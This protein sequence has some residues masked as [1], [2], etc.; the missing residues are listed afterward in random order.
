M[1]EPERSGL[2]S[3]SGWATGGPSTRRP[4]EY[5]GVGVDDPRVA[6]CIQ[7]MQREAEL[8]DRREYSRWEELFAEDGVYVIPVDRDAEQF[9][10]SLNMVFDD[11]QMRSQRVRRMTEGYAIAAVDAAVTARVLGRFVAE[12]V[13]D[14]GGTTLVAVRAA[15]ILVAFKRQR[16]ELWAGDVDILVRLGDTPEQDRIVRK[17]VRLVDAGDVV[18]AAGFLL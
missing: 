7:L 9:E 2:W 15:Q 11:G 3:S 1:S 5:A 14:D 8:L 6:R 12:S 16:H 4:I 10:D 13:V 17:V 18:P